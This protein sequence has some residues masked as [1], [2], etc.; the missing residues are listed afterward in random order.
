[1]K[2]FLSF[3]VLV[4]AL[5]LTGCATVDTASEHGFHSDYYKFEKDK[6]E[7][8]RAYAEVSE[9]SISIYKLREG[10]AGIPEPESVIGSKISTIGPENYLFNSRFVK[11]SIEFDLS[12]II[13]KLRPAM[14]GVP[15]QLNANLNALLYMGARKDFYIV[16]TSKSVLNRNS[17]KIK[18]LGYDFGIFGGIGITPVNPTVTNNNTDLEYD[19]MVF[20]KGVG[21]FITIDNIS[22]GLTLGFDNLLNSDSK[23]WIY[24]NKPYIGIAIGIA[25]F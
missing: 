4:P 20:Q 10:N 7:V 11:N 17:S 25:N 16:R 8:A 22:V 14:S 15:V 3:A 23:I 5:L 19:G 18:H 2:D 13:T 1:M 6:K 24:N 9:D 21:A 12:T